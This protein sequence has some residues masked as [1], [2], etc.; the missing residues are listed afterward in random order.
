[1]SEIATQRTKVRMI[2]AHFYLI[3]WQQK[4]T[5]SQ[6]RLPWNLD[7]FVRV[8][9]VKITTPQSTDYVTKISK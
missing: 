6:N 7:F 3:K 1:M 4:V 8:N 5:N 2:F 9:F